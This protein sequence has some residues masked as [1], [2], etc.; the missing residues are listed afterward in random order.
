MTLLTTPAR[1]AHA[2]SLLD[3]PDNISTDWIGNSGT[4]YFNFVHRF[5]VSPPPER[6]VTNF[7]TFLIATGI[8]S[9]ALVGVNYAT[10]SALEARY[11]NE[12]EF[13][14]RYAPVQQEAGAPF[15]LGGQV[16]YNLA[17]KGWDGEVSI[18]R[19]EGPVRL[20][21]LTRLIAD[22]L[23]GSASRFAFGGGGTVRL[24]RF[25]AL[26]G[27]AVSLTKRDN[28]ETV[29]WSAG[30]HV[31]LP[32]TPHTLS[33][34]ISNAGTSTLQGFTRGG[35]TRRYGFEFTIPLPLAR[36]FGSPDETGGAPIAG[37]TPTDSSVA[38]A[39][40]TNEATA[41]TAATATIADSAAPPA[42]ATPPAAP[43]AAPPSAPARVD[44]V[45]AKPAA[46]PATPT[47]SK[48][49][50]AAPAAKPAPRRP[51][52]APR[53]AA[54][55]HVSI[56]RIKAQSFI[57][58]RLEIPVGTTVRWNN[59]DA[60][61]HTVTATDKSFSSGIISADG[62]YSHT[63]TKPGTYSIFCM[64]HPFMKATIVVK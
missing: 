27:D 37:M 7:P 1:V 34:H 49:A 57:P 47:P 53:T 4:F 63:F 30:I 19:R 44:S 24:G 8:D 15:D 16:D 59:L 12:W 2:Q 29:A 33:I 60:L 6:K 45:T 5:S 25:L 31:A 26:A 55:A 52:P 10:N 43:P 50:P 18:A 28:G 36:F 23:G 35:H 3:R 56:A 38:V 14:G 40:A 13:F 42:A 41:A 62:S 39:S 21:G 20:V 46:Q 58:G 11:P 61:M 48:S 32:N 17:V 51:A 64:I 54:A 22:T 9:K